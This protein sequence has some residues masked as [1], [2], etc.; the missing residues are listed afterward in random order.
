MRK[1][2]DLLGEKDMHLKLVDGKLS[3]KFP[4]DG[5]DSELLQEIKQ[6]KT[7]LIAYLTEQANPTDNPFPMAV[8][9]LDY[10]LSSAQRR[11]WVLSQ[12][13]E[14]NVAYNMPGAY[15]FEGPVDVPSLRTAF[16]RLIDRHEIL[17][18]TF[19]EN[20]DGDVRQYIASSDRSGFS[21]LEEDL[22]NVE[23]Q[24]VE[25]R[26]LVDRE[27][28]IPFNLSEGPLL[29]AGIY[30]LSRDRWLFTYTM[31][32][33]ISDGWSLGVLIRELLWYYNSLVTGGDGLLPPLR[34]QYKDYSVWQRSL[35]EGGSLE[36]GRGYW[37]DVFSGD[38]PVL[39]LATDRPRPAV[40][41]Y[42]GGVVRGVLGAGPT[43][44]LKDLCREK[45]GTL[46]MGL[47]AG[48]KSLLYRYTGQEDII[49]GSPI[50]GRS[51]L[52]LEDQIGFYVNTLALRTR[53]AGG[54]GFGELLSNVR[55]VS[56]GAFEHQSYPFDELVDQLDLQQ[57]MSRNALFDVMVMLQNTQNI[58]LDEKSPNNFEIIPYSG[59]SHETSKFDLSFEFEE[60]DDGI[61]MGIEYNSDIYDRSTIERMLGHFERLMGSAV[62]DPSLPLYRLEYLGAEER[63]ELLE[64]FND[65]AADYPRE[66]TIIDLFGEQVDKRPNGTALVFGD[67]R[68]TYQE[69]NESSNRMAR[70]LRDRHGIGKEDMVGICLE[71]SDWMVVCILG[72]L[73]AGGAYVPI[74][75]DYP[76]DRIRYMLEDIACKVL[77][78]SDEL[79][80]YREEL[81]SLSGENLPSVVGPK[82]LAY[83]IYTS[84][85]TGKPKGVMTEHSSVVSFFENIYKFFSLH[86]KS[87]WAAAANYTFDI[88][89]LEIL[90]ALTSGMSVNLLQ[91]DPNALLKSIKKG[92]VDTLQI[93]P[94]RL[95]QLMIVADNK[96]ESLKKLKVILIGG[97]SL[98]NDNYLKLKKLT[99]TKVYNI[100]G[101][102]E[103]TLWSN[104]LLIQESN[105]LSIGKPLLNY[106]IY[107]LGMGNSLCPIGVV[108]ELCISGDGL[109]RGYLNNPGLSSEKFVS[110]PY[111]EGDL[112][113]RTGDLGRWLVDGTIEFMGRMDHQVKVRGHR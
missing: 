98:T 24:K 52:D 42:N 31:H 99:T 5:L 13:E 85:S 11:L 28:S 55:E 79:S 73:K 105:Q 19:R 87:C 66:R 1:F 49:I 38:L 30:R 80:L 91:G 88:S 25:V 68:I 59:K 94:A 4:K 37:S 15:I 8:D 96:V 20:G 54:S 45:G 74:D 108:G 34:I 7:E 16:E 12:F 109:A 44:L 43:E 18:T 47:L 14:G 40:K 32:H 90:G 100:Y 84:G 35:L 26:S 81:D 3:L 93:T 76:E 112:M 22:R 92:E 9:S 17:R 29:R 6:R 50:A 97:E 69:L 62:A 39:N 41:T 78:D 70:Y 95:E 51:H 10:E 57:D 53:F 60:V 111:C 77:I 46:Y 58:A 21:L 36:K 82:N 56:L 113:Y 89:V 110:N 106:R 103:T 75:P 83:V 27:A 63:R 65:T 67:K 102:T 33:I 86:P 2:L 72:I 61:A 64:T 104:A 101:T 71:R 48:V 107:I 23:G